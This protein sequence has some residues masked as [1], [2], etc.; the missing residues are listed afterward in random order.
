MARDWKTWHDEYDEP[1][2]RLA[3]RLATVQRFLH[4]ALSDAPPG[5]IRAISVCAGEGRDLLGVLEEHPRAGDVAARL[6]ELDPELATR[7]RER[8]PA[9]VEVVC[10]D[11]STTATYQGAVP[12][13]LV[14]VC[15][16]FGNVTDED[17]QRTVAALPSLC[18]EGATVLWTRHRFPPDLTPEIRRWFGE[19]GFEEVGFHGPDDE[20]F[21]V[22]AQ[23]FVGAPRPVAPDERLFTFVGSDELLRRRPAEPSA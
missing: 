3:R 15:G 5:P 8:A 18:A 9:G 20:L 2:S 4:R 13:D 19:A 12:A 23:R 10:G 21:G 11:A 1:D 6:V 16:V 17:V 7:A 14:L 22:G